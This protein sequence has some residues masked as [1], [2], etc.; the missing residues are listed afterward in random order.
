MK[1]VVEI[2]TIFEKVRRAQRKGIY[3]PHKP[4]LILLSLARVQQGNHRLSDFSRLEVH[5]KS[6]LASFGPSSAASTR[7]LP[8]WHLRTD[9]AGGLWEL[10]G[11]AEILSRPPASAPTLG[12]LRNGHVLGGFVP[13]V[14]EKLKATPDLIRAVAQQ[15]LESAFPQTLFEEIVA[16]T[17][18]DMT[19]VMHISEPELLSSYSQIQRR[20]RDP[21]FRERVLRA[22]EY[23][24][25]VCGF[26]LRVCH[27]PA[28]LEAAHIQWHTT[29]GP[30]VEPN[31]LS[32][33]ALHHK[34]FDLGAFSIEP[35][36][37]RIVYSQHA[38]SSNRSGMTELQFH[39]RQ[40]LSPQQLDQ[41]P[42]REFLHWNQRN[43]FKSP[44]R[45]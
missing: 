24:C 18:L 3:S 20:K 32:L 34:L 40:L 25:C 38:I 14:Y 28:G 5:L 12:E 7:H 8:F 37:Y 13:E 44:C 35:A 43:V 21:S 1:T 36:D 11:P 30:D 9:A 16:A 31:G 17:G 6:L 4:L 26:D 45:P 22:Y 29:G 15:I 19:L 23:R 42:G 39:G 2:L 27:L 10:Q 33:C 41:L